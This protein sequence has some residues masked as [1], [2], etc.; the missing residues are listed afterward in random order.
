MPK[1]YEDG[2]WTIESCL[3]DTQDDTVIKLSADTDEAK[4]DPFDTLEMTLGDTPMVVEL[5]R[6]YADGPIGT[7]RLGVKLDLG[8]VTVCAERKGSHLTLIVHYG[9][10]SKQIALMSIDDAKKLADRLEIASD[11]ATEHFEAELIKGVDFI[12]A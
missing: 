1:L 4:A 9:S 10:L 2:D 6:D 11:K 12:D 7:E 5:I 8:D 3:G